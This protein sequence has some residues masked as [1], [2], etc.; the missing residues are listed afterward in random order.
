MTRTLKD[1]LDERAASLVGRDRE[2]TELL[3]LVDDDRPLVAM[4][5]GIAGVGKSTLLRAAAARARAKHATVMQL[6]GGSIE[7]TP[8]GFLSALGGLLGC[9]AATADDAG[10]LLATRGSRTVLVVDTLDRLRLLDDWLRQSLVPALPDN[11]RLLLAGRDPLSPAWASALGELL[12]FIRLENLAVGDARQ[13]LR[14]AGV[15]ERDVD[16]LNRFAHGHPLTLRL[17]A[18][19]LATRPEMSIDQVAVPS[20]M[21]EL[22]RVYL[23]GLEPETRRAL[24]AAAVVRRSTRSL[25]AAM[26]ETD[27]EEAW[28]RLDGLPFAEVGPDGLVLHDTLR[29]AIDATLRAADPTRRRRLRM[30]AFRQLQ[31]EVRDATPAELWRYTSDLLFLADNPLIRDGFFPTGGPAFS[32]EAAVEVD[33]SAIIAIAERHEGG[34]PAA[35]I[36]A[37][38]EAVP[39]GFRVARDRTGAVTAFQLLC[40]SRAVGSN[41]VARDPVASRWRLDLRRRPLPPDAR[42]LFVRHML[43]RDGGE[44]LSPAQAALWLDAK[45]MYLELRPSLQRTYTAVHRLD[46]LGSLLEPLGFAELPGPPPELDGT[47]Y[48]VMALDFGAG[49]V[50]GWLARLVAAELGLEGG[51]RL[52]PE[53]R[54]LGLNGRRVALTQLEYDLLSHLHERAGRP[55]PRVEL[56]AEVWGHQW[57]GDGNV[58]EV[59]VSALRRKL[60][61]H[62]GLIQ[63]VRGIGYRWSEP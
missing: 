43:T 30:A 29:E 45:R 44:E 51:P 41:V 22:T 33:R 53:R 50:D 4:V 21:A 60:G 7:P 18:S 3:R 47:T 54:E 6:E 63:T 62:A 55:V 13:L 12:S 24:D 26:L 23:D 31:S 28:R 8:Q 42:V 16:R 36:D 61:D 19:A 20:V 35:T 5:H 48:H 40:D 58:I 27:G 9:P 34:S 52:D 2:L 14:L 49:S 38:W 25:L 1:I 37:W 11:V 32:I 17:A 56:L 46:L 57:P 15:A 10:R 39:Q 59:A